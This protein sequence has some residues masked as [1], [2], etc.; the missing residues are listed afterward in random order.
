MPKNYKNRAMSTDKDTRIKIQ[1][2]PHQFEML[3]RIAKSCN[4]SVNE[5]VERYVMRLIADRHRP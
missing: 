3:E 1:L 5:V 4:L 2:T